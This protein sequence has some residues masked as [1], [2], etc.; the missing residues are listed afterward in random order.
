LTVKVWLM[1][2]VLPNP[3]GNSLRGASLLTTDQSPMNER[4]GGWYVT[5]TYGAQRH[6]GNMVVRGLNVDFPSIKDY[7]PRLNL[8]PGANVTDLRSRFDT[9][10][11]PIPNSDIVALML[12]AHQ[13][14]VH[15]LITLATYEVQE[16]EKLHPETTEKLVKEDGDLLVGAM[17]FS[18]AAAFTDPIAG[19]SV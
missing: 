13:T 17:L 7:I 2:S 6:L 11:Y 8:D 16:A 3:A 9:K 15:N 19:T 4:W 18:G 5:G 12:L 14:H 10:R 1:L